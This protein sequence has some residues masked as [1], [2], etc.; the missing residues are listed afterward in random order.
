[1]SAPIATSTRFC[2][3]RDPR[4]FFLRSLPSIE[5]IYNVLKLIFACTGLACSSDA[6]AHAEAHRR[7]RAQVP[8]VVAPRK[9]IR[10]TRSNPSHSF[11]VAQKQPL[12]SQAVAL[13]L[14]RCCAP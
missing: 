6:S 3:A 7:N 8:P 12:K 10:K 13:R 14:R 9:L 2:I 1:M 11:S 5:P 4:F